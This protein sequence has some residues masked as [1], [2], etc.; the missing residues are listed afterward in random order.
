MR[1]TLNMFAT[2]IFLL[3]P[4]TAVAD[5]PAVQ[6]FSAF[7]ENPVGIKEARSVD[8]ANVLGIKWT[9][10]AKRC[11]GKGTTGNVEAACKALETRVGNIKS[12]IAKDQLLGAR[13]QVL[14]VP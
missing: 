12:F 3:L 11:R 1:Q 2:G 10:A 8:Q 13:C 14:P 7:L 5:T 9:C 6:S 4:S